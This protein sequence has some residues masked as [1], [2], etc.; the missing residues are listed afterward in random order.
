MFQR[1]FMISYLDE[2]ILVCFF[3]TCSD[4]KI[5]YTDIYC[6]LCT[7]TF[8]LTWLMHFFLRKHEPFYQ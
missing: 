5:V 1:L 7:V 4:I 2:E 8:K 6:F 3:N